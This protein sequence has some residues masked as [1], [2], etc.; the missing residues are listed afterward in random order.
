MGEIKIYTDE[1][2]DVAIVQGLQRRG[3]EAF[4]ARDR[5]KLGLTD[6]EQLIFASKGKATIFTH[7]TDFLQIAAQWNDQGRTHCGVIYCHQNA[8]GIGDCIRNLKILVTV[9]TQE[10][11]I[12]HIEFL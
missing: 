7:D 2:V 6:E 9:L 4:S 5:D 12:D 1:S 8:H 10:D 11:M 3:V